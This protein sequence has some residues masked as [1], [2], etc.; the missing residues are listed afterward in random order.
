MMRCHSCLK[1]CEND[2]CR[3][4]SRK[5]FGK[6][7]FKAKL[8]FTLPDIAQGTG[9]GVK[10]ISISGA[11]V[12]FSLKFEGRKLATTDRNG[13]YILKPATSMR[14]RL[15]SD[16][17]ANEHVTMQMAKQI[18]KMDVAESALL[19]F[20]SGEFA[21]L[22]KRFDVR[23]D[24]TRIH[25]EDFAQVADLSSGNAGSNFKYESISYE[26][27][28][29]LMK[30][31][32]SAYII[33]VEKFFKII[34]FNYL[35]CNGDAHV[36]NFSIYSPNKEGVFVLTPAYDLLN[37]SLHASDERMALDL[38][39]NEE[40][41][42]SEFFKANGFYGA[43]DFME[44]AKRVGIAE[45]RAERFIRETI[46]HLDEMDEMIDV[47]FLSD[48]AKAKYKECIRDRAKALMIS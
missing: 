44:F 30:Q 28:A 29:M 22:T 9:D 1:G 3:S 20:S 24:D 26:E 13:V 10:R 19:E 42:E 34:L 4:C 21:Y 7:K 12:K 17:P 33:A 11:Q 18:F 6:D 16:M 8:D 46:G 23:K 5:I 41:Y 35:V 39:A 32:V 2:F 48:E 15:F 38:F 47:S 43:P 27:I 45:K 25:Q 36:K 31:H 40:E 37:T 14:F